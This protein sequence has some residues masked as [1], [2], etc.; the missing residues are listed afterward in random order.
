M[1]KK[2]KKSKRFDVLGIR[3][4]RPLAKAAIQAVQT[5]LGKVILAEALIQAAAMLTTRRPTAAA[6]A[7]GAGAAETGRD[8]AGGIKG[9]AAKF[10][11]GAAELLKASVGDG[12]PGKK[13]KNG[14]NAASSSSDSGNAAGRNGKAP[15]SIW[16]SLDAEMVR[17]ALLGEFTRKRKK[18][19]ASGK[20]R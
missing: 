16:E 11:H 7:I 8:L 5:P 19:S 1:A 4:P 10:L 15:V 13:H 12:K 17:D 18:K 2:R 9:T 6:A 14:K 3:V 20:R